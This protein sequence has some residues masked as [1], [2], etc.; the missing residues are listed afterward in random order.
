MM[1]SMVRNI[2]TLS[3]LST[4]GG[5]LSLI[6]GASVLFGWYTNN[7]V[8]IQVSAA[9]VPMQYNTALGFLLSGL[10]LI[11]AI[12]GS[13]GAGACGILVMLIGI[14]T[15]AEYLFGIDL[16]IDQLLMQHYIT[17]ET[18]HPGRMAP[19]TALCFSLIGIS[20][21]LLVHSKTVWRPYV[22]VGTLGSLTLGLGIVAMAGYAFSIETAYGWGNLTR[23]AVHTATGFMILGLAVTSFAWF[24][25][26]SDSSLFPNWSSLPVGIGVMTITVSL[27]QALSSHDD[28][29]IKE[30]GIAE[31]SQYL[32][33]ALLV[34]GTFL[35]VALSMAVFFALT[36]R[37][38]RKEVETI[39]R[40]LAI[41]IAEH[42]QA[43][44]SVRKLSQAIEQAGES[45]VITDREGVIEYVNPAFTK[46][47]G[48]SAEEAIGQTPRILKSGKQDAA[49]YEDMWNTISSGNTWSGK[50][51]DKR[52][53]GSFYPITL[54]I[55]PIFDQSEDGGICTHFVGIQSDLTELDNMEHQFH[56]AQKME[57]VGTLVGGIAHD[58]N[59]M[60]AGM[61]G[62]LYLA[63]KRT[64]E[65][66]D[67]IQKLDNI[68]EIAFRAAAMIQQM[69]AF[70]RKGPVSMKPLP[71][72]LFTKETLRLLRPSV[73]ENIKIDQDICNDLF[74]ISGDS[75]QLHQVLMNLV[76]NAR[77]ALEDVDDPCMTIRLEPF[78]AKGKFVEKHPYFTAGL[79][80]HLSVADNGCGIPEHQIRH[81]FEPFFTTKEQ[82][83]GTGLG[84]AMVFGAIKTHQ[85]FIE[86]ESVEGEGTA[87][88]IYLPLLESEDIATASPQKQEVAE[89][90][91]ELILLV[92]DQ[93][94]VIET[95]KEVLESFGY[96]VLTAIDGQQAVELFETHAD[97][98]DLIIMDVVMP[99]MGGHKAA[100]CIRQI[101]PAAKIIL[102]TGY[103]ENIQA[104]LEN[105]T[106]LSKPFS[107]EKM[108]H[109]VRQKLDT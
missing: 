29:L 32:N 103:D 64:H 69:L 25:S 54:T 3:L 60:L 28:Q 35:A 19:N 59:N 88:H 63:K 98:I 4:I 23:M 50:V 96:Q 40:R 45:I 15:L 27:W 95:G 49:F 75:T 70:A 66:P 93:P 71:F 48:Y 36:A 53:D 17:V 81:L 94:Q 7:I 43:E 106:V 5:V 65:M 11:L 108:S 18:S 37:N 101:N 85:G 47:S 10:G 30:Y 89:G 83:K 44:K 91:G 46:L 56:Q 58:F 92:D 107:I 82:G 105:E 42:K 52:K 41:E 100:Q 57:A 9:F 73:P 77:D 74:Q 68:E 79:Y 22:V 13:R 62:N 78:H 12:R 39:N 2:S 20:L 26:I 8:L 99:V 34:F 31:H 33:S 6:L 51:I 109:L 38:R 102:A 21:T 86:V 67:V 87:F 14:L 55:S 90:H 80:A 97:E 1:R 16:S 24:R 72:I 84:L 76:T 61:T 104:D